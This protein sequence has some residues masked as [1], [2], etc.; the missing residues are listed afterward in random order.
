M[1]I[2]MVGLKG[3]KI[4]MIE[5]DTLRYALKFSAHLFFLKNSVLLKYFTSVFIGG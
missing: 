2:I 5:V 4:G 3:E 1:K